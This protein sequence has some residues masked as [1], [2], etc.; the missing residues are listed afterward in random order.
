MRNKVNV[1]TS[2]LYFTVSFS[3]YYCDKSTSWFLITNGEFSLL[4]L[5]IHKQLFK[6][7]QNE[8]MVKLSTLQHAQ[9][10][11]KLISHSLEKVFVNVSLKNKTSL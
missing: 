6:K 11:L 1:L 3:I 9:C 10:C 7:V 8:F 2:T 5:K 4:K